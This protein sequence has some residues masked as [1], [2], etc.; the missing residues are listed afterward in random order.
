METNPAASNKYKIIY[1][2][3]VISVFLASDILWNIYSE[4]SSLY[5][6]LMVPWV[7]ITLLCLGL[8]ILI[9]FM[10]IIA[11]IAQRF[12][13]IPASFS[14][15][16]TRINRASIITFILFAMIVFLHTASW[17]SFHYTGI[18]LNLDVFKMLS[19]DPVQLMQHVTH[20]SVLSLFFAIFLTLL[21][22]GILTY[23]LDKIAYTLATQHYPATKAL[24]LIVISIITT[25]TVVIIV[26]I[27]T[28]T[29]KM[30][31]SQTGIAYT[32]QE[33]FN[34]TLSQR[35][36]PVASL[37][38]DIKKSTTP[39]L[40]ASDINNHAEFISTKKQIPINKYLDGIQVTK[41]KNIVVLLIESLRSDQ[42]PI[43][44]GKEAIMPTLQQIASSSLVY[45]NAY[46]T[47]SHS[48]YSDLGPLSSHYP[49]RSINVHYYPENPSYPRVLLHDILKPLGYKTAI[50]SS[51]NEHWGNMLN[52]LDT[53][54]LDFILHAENYEGILRQALSNN[55]APDDP[56]MGDKKQGKIDDKF[57]VNEAIKWI[58]EQKNQPF[59]IYMNL[60]SSHFPYDV[61]DKYLEDEKYNKPELPKFMGSN[62][63]AIDQEAFKAAYQHSLRYIDKHIARLVN[64]LK[65]KSLWDDTIL[66]VS[67]DT[68]TAFFEHGQWG[69]GGPLYD[70]VVKVPLFIHNSDTP[71]QIDNTLTSHIDV[72]PT[73][74]D[75]L[76]LPPHPSFQGL[77]TIDENN[78]DRNERP[79]FLVCQSPVG[80]QYAV[81]KNEWKLIFDGNQG[82][83]I[84]YKLDGANP[85][86]YD[87][88]SEKNELNNDLTNLLFTWMNTQIDYYQQKQWHQREYPPVVNNAR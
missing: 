9:A 13:S 70:E 37:I 31:D 71:H 47:S 60:Q 59:M 65:E 68:A 48:N 30:T 53:G 12:L 86:K 56:L 69:N 6:Q 10:S 67:A 4:R 58:D 25:G 16:Y 72:M 29:G 24:M 64:H 73:V 61:S 7:R 32:P 8:V 36:G 38:W 43:Y 46:A 74:L 78:K 41:K 55:S 54:N 77:S 3:L 87:Y 22:A 18:F 81:V 15:G 44:G 83:K 33:R 23:R 49:L 63:N 79:I 85:E 51:Q 75:M 50:I 39:I 84:L 62:I 45:T 80:Y 1:W 19:N 14:H 42:F 88:A 76:G 17:L 52:Y 11:A 34:E 26:T 20:I 2:A 66:V 35:T 21:I 27:S 5:D 28:S 57:T 82:R 40:F